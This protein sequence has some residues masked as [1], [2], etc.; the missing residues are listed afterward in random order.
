[1]TCG[2]I[3]LTFFFSESL[4]PRASRETFWLTDYE[5]INCPLLNIKGVPPWGHMGVKAPGKIHHCH[6]ETPT[7]KVC[8]YK[9]HATPFP[10]GLVS[11]FLMLPCMWASVNELHLLSFFCV[12]CLFL[13]HGDS[14]TR[15]LGSVHLPYILVTVLCVTLPHSHFLFPALSELFLKLKP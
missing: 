12:Q 8:L 3:L 14:R 11:L 2:D 4:C 6:S 13:Q 7:F 15:S 5:M 9:A 10:G 1:M